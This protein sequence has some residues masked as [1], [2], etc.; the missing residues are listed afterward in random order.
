MPP[1]LRDLPPDRLAL[2]IANLRNL[3]YGVLPRAGAPAA[4]LAAAD[5]YVR[6]R[7]LARLALWGTVLAAATRGDPAP[8]DAV[9][10]DFHVSDAAIDVTAD[11]PPVT[12]ATFP[13]RRRDIFLCWD[14]C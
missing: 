3:A 8:D 2:E 6:L 9:H 14:K 13:S 7:E 5:E 4:L 10:I 1:D 12:I 11:A